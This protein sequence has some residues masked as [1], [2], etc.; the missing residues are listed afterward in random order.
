MHAADAKPLV[1]LKVSFGCL[2]HVRDNGLGELPSPCNSP[3][4]EAGRASKEKRGQLRLSAWDC[5]LR[6]ATTSR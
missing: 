6:A 4:P 2:N 5:P 3:R 1:S